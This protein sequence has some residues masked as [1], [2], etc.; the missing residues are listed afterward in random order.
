L[1]L[2]RLGVSDVCI[3]SCLVHWLDFGSLVNNKFRV[4]R[5]FHC[6]DLSFG[7]VICCPNG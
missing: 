6:W 3:L 1:G 4:V 5:V 7:V 2:Y